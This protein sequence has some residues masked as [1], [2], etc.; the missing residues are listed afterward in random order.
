MKGNPPAKQQ[1]T[2]H[3]SGTSDPKSRKVDHTDETSKR[4]D[5]ERDFLAQGG[6]IEIDEKGNRKYK[7]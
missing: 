3:K 1:A 4:I 6:T 7:K 5:R 2:P